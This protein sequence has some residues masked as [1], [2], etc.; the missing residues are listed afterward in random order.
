MVRCIGCGFCC[1]EMPCFSV[2][3]IH[4]PVRKCPELVWNG[5]C[6][7][8]RIIEYRREREVVTEFC[9]YPSNVWRLDV[10]QREEVIENE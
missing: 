1:I 5:E 6:Y 3:E 2:M 10:K 4:G 7:L 9:C 8:C